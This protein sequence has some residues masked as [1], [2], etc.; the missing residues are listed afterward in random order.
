[1][2]RNKV[3][4]LRTFQY[5]DKFVFVRKVEKI[6]ISGGGGGSIDKTLYRHEEIK[7]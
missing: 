3:N 6:L 4:D 2:F 5:L 1:M 7:V